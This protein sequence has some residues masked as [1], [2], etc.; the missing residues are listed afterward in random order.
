MWRV[1]TIGVMVHS[2]ISTFVKSYVS[3][4]NGR[5]EGEL[6]GS[7]DAV[8]LRDCLKKFARTHIYLHRQ[9]LEV[10]LKGHQTIHAL[11]DIFWVAINDQTEADF[12]IG[13]R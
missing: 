11:M 13:K 8:H 10:E 2:A 1:D 7:S 3:I 4:M 5:F 12:T 6:I 9:V